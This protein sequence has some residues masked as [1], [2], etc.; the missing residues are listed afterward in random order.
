M[1][2]MSVRTA[3]RWLGTT[4]IVSG[5]LVLA[6]VVL[7]WQ[8]QDP[9]TALYTKWEQREL[10]SEYAHK[11]AEYRSPRVVAHSKK[12]RDLAAYELSIAAAARRYRHSLHEGDPIGR[13]K[14]P[15]LGLNMI[16][17]NGTDTDTLKKGPARDLQSYLPGEGRLIYVAG[18]R[19]TYLAPFSNIDQ[20]RP[21]DPVTLELPYG[22]FTYRITGHRIVDANDLSVLRSH[23][24][25]LLAL[26]ACHPRF[27][28]THRYIA[29]AKPVSVRPWDGA[30][31][32]YTGTELAALGRRA[33]TN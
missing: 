15:R 21:G 32:R 2:P 16:F 5:V 18:H 13:I 19:T 29:Y 24:R 17:V 26:Q 11:V 25:E 31:Y 1:S 9:F 28:A 20:L 4:L 10:R 3:F 14:V 8:W 33:L 27:F 22:V 7:V 23:G 6:W 30:P 12:K